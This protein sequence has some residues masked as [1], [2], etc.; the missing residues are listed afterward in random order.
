VLF[1]GGTHWFSDP[2]NTHTHTHHTTVM[3]EEKEKEEKKRI[4]SNTTLVC[5]VV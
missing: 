4:S 2:S 5:G 3:G 1:Y